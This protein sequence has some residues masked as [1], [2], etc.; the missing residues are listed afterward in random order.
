VAD[1]EDLAADRLLRALEDRDDRPGDVLHMA[2]RTPG[3]RVVDDQLLADRH[4][5]GELRDRQVEPHPR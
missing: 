1:V 4:R 3:V 2:V 5:A